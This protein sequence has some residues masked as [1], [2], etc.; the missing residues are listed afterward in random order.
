MELIDKSF[1]DES[2]EQQAAEEMTMIEEAIAQG[3]EMAQENEAEMRELIKHLKFQPEAM[4]AENQ[5]EDEQAEIMAKEA[6]ERLQL[7]ELD[8]EVI[9]DEI[10]DQ[11][12]LE[13]QLVGGGHPGH[14][15]DIHPYHAWWAVHR[16]NEGGV[17]L[18]S[19][20]L[21]RSER[22]MFLYAK[23]RG[24]GLG[25]TDDNDV[26]VYGRFFYG[27]WPRKI[28]SVRVYVPLITRGWYQIRS[29]DKWWN[30][31]EAKTEVSF[32]VRLFQNF[33]GPVKERRIFRRFGR[34]INQA[35][36]IDQSQSLYSDPMAVGANKW[37]IA[38]VTCKL[39]VETEGSGTLAV[40][41][42]RRPDCI[43]VPGVRFDFS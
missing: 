39:R 36:R 11:F 42:F 24:D 27:F 21:I 31:K 28:G 3:K 29:N 35:N 23:A 41:S 5:K 19:A 16:H 2:A 25:I 34:N 14:Y 4:E 18:G 38:M 13:T 17:T 8:V 10:L 1:L 15:W 32:S 22:K 33:W 6:E 20:Q 7:K 40:L 30:S 9:G 43:F 12:A 37:V 26:T